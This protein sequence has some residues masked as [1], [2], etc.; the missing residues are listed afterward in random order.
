M[1]YPITL[2]RATTTLDAFGPSAFGSFMTKDSIGSGMAFLVGELEKLDPKLREPLTS[3]TW[4]RDIPVQTGGGFVDGVSAF[5][6]DYATSG[7]SDNGIIGSQTNV[8]PVM[9]ADIGRDTYRTFQWAHILKVPYIDQQKMQKIGRSLDEILNRGI[10][11]EYDKRLDINVYIG[12]EQHGTYGLVNSPAIPVDM[13]AEGES[14]QTEWKTKTAVEIMTD[15]N[16]VLT[17]TWAASE[18]DLTGMANHILIPP[19]Q[20]AYI[21]N[22]PCAIGETG[23]AQSVLTYLLQNNIAKS[24]GVDLFIL[25]CRWCEGAGQSGLDRMVAYANDEDR[26]RF[27]ITVPLHRVLTQ[28]SAE[29]MAYLTPFLSQFSEVQ[30][31]YTQHGYYLDGI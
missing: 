5:N 14:T 10:R 20:Y 4:P 19:E 3:T 9:Q 23:T 6:V 13:A 17:A 22:T 28:P 27:S 30:W 21:N 11:I 8:I 29:Q 1:P 25:P 26:V 24:Q 18:Y 2:P 7:G 15:I 12:M 31:L 16:D